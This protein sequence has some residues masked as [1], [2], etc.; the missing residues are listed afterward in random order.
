MYVNLIDLFTY[1]FIASGCVDANV[2]KH[3]GL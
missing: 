3:T 2:I 1:L